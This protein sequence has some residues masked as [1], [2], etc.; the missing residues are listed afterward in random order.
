VLANKI[1]VLSAK[2]IGVEVL[3]IILDKSF[4]YTR[5]NR[6]HRMEPCGTPYLSLAQSFLEWI[7]SF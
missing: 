5:K 3:F 1:T 2:M 7:K 4:T 6:G